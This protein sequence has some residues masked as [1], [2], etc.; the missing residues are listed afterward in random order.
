MKLAAD[1][2][3]QSVSPNYFLSFC[4]KNAFNTCMNVQKLYVLGIKKL[5]SCRYYA[6]CI[7]EHYYAHSGMT[8][9]QHNIL[10]FINFDWINPQGYINSY[11]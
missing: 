10:D 1:A 9:K 8:T 11:M 2:L 6:S 3:D 7:F 4:C 5:F